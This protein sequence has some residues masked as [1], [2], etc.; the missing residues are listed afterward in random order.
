MAVKL[1]PLPYAPDALAPSISAETLQFH[2]EKH[3][4][5]YV[6]KVNELVRGKPED[7]MTLEEI[8][9]AAD[10]GTV[11]FNNAAQAWNHAFYW[12]SMCAGG[13]GEPKGA[14]AE[15]IRREF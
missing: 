9:L 10:P 11:L 12:N 3:H 15:S 14:I 5:A 1:P 8:V 7:G 4:A 6:D 13:G 2:H